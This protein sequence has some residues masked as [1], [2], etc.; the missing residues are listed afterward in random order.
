MAVLN[1][2]ITQLKVIFF[3]FLR[4][5]VVLQLSNTRWKL[6]LFKDFKLLSPLVAYVLQTHQCVTRW[7]AA[8]RP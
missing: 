4:T 3:N 7:K 6:N 8:G 2:G 5:A 1:L